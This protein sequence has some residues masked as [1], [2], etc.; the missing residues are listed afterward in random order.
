MTPIELVV[1][2]TFPNAMD[3]ELAKSALDSADIDSF[4][5]A[6]DAGGMRPHLAMPHVRLLVRVEDADRATDILGPESN[7]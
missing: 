7:A 2:R 1:V 4:V 6:D 5:Q 3:A